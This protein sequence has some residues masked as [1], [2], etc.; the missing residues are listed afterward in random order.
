MRLVLQR[1]TA[2]SVR[3]G[4]DLVGAIGP[5]LLVLVGVGRDDTHPLA[6]RLARKVA[7]QRIFPDPA[8]RMNVSLLEIEGAALVVSQFTLYGETRK[9]NRPSFGGAAPPD[10]AVGVLAEFV[11]ELRSVGIEVQEGRFGAHMEVSLVNDGP[12]TILM[13]A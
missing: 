10:L 7:A 4:E 6:R 3:V 8:G 13:E 11:H 2:A 9:G 5:G 12:V 1:V